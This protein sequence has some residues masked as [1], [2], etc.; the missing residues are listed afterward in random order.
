MDY[1]L[2]EILK[3][4]ND[5]KSLAFW[6]KAILKLGRQIVAEEVSETKYQTKIGNCKS[7]AK[8]LTSLLN[9][10]LK[11]TTT[12]PKTKTEKKENYFE[13]TQLDLFQNLMPI[14]IPEKEKGDFKAMTMPYSSKNI[15]WPTFLGPEFFTLS[16]N[17]NKSDKVK[18]TSHAMDGSA[19]IISLI[20]GKISPTGKERGI[21]TVQH[22]KIFAALKF[23]WAQQGCKYTQFENETVICHVTTSARE[24]AKTLGWKTFGGKELIRLKDAIM[25]LKSMPYYLDFS[26]SSIKN[27]KSYYFTLVSD[28]SGIDLKK[29]GGQAA[30]FKISFSSAVSW[31]LLQRHAVMRSKNILSIRSELATLLWLYI[32]P[33]LRT[34]KD[35]KI[36]LKNLIK[37]LQLPKA[38][39]HKYPAHRKKEFNKAIKELNI[40]ALIDDHKIKITIEKGLYDWQ[41]CGQIK[42]NIERIEK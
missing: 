2:E 14:K 11:K 33:I 7:P 15:P 6:K 26:E 22:E 4:T 12:N 13:K 5:T 9:A 31:Q 16:T 27:I 38:E 18:M 29:Q 32:E 20:R 37:A 28:F 23:I 10:K 35:F 30:Y 3:L 42:E 25:D 1:V 40:L 21:P 41:L 8:Y 17:K 24:L 34:H 19:V 36:N 39:W